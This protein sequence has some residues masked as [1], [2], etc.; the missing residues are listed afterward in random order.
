MHNTPRLL[1]WL[2]AALLCCTVA[3]TAHAWGERGH[4]II[5]HIARTL[6]TPQARM[7]I[8]QLMDSDDLA[9]MA[10]YLDQRKEEVEREIPGSKQWHYDNVPVCEARRYRDYC[11]QEQRCASAQIVR[12]AA[13]LAQRQTPKPE[14]QFALRVLAHLVG[15]LHQPLH[16]ADNHDQGGNAVNVTFPDGQTVRLHEAWDS[17]FVQRRFGHERDTAIAQRLITQYAKQ[18]SA[19]QAGTITLAQIQTWAREGNQVAQKLAYG[20]L[21]GFACRAAPATSPIALS[22]DYLTSANLVIAEQL[23]KAGYRLA[24]VL[25]KSVAR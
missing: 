4:R 8:E 11:P 7:A 5:G 20:K 18:A 24:A 16:T 14:K 12:H 9:T 1:P 2:S 23:A 15:D 6:L 19:W 13:L 22:Q 25:N 3:S 17:T 10:L 21:P